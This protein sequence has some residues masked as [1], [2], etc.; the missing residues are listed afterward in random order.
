MSS[1]WKRRS[2]PIAGITESRFPG[3]PLDMDMRE[4][5]GGLRPGFAVLSDAGTKRMETHNCVY[6]FFLFFS[7]GLSV[8]HS[9]VPCSSAAVPTGGP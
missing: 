9:G 4:S 2:M 1:L 5:T 3:S 7:L 8:W 6:P